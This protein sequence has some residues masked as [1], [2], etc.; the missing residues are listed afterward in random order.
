MAG[1][2]VNELINLEELDLSSNQISNISVNSNLCNLIKLN[3]EINYFNE[4]TCHQLFQSNSFNLTDLNL[5][6]LPIGDEIMNSNPQYS[7]LTH[8]QMRYMRD[9]KITKKSIPIIVD[10]L[11]MLRELC[12]DGISMGIEECRYI[13]QSPCFRNM[14][15][16][17]LAD[18]K[19]DSRGGLHIDQN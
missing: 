9:S 2:K 18:C 1:C 8:L 14:T 7:K 6:Y 11:T 12:L 3:L 5:S 4:T 19:I 15:R 10:T 13:T 17:S 16:L